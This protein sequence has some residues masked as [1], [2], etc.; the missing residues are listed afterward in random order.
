[1]LAT[2][3]D[4]PF[5][6]D[7]NWL[8]EIKWDGFRA[9]ARVDAGGFKLLGR[10]GTDFTDRFKDLPLDRLPGGT[11]V[12]GELVALR[13]D[14]KPDFTALLKSKPSGLLLAYVA[15]DLL[16]LKGQSVMAQPCI[17]RRE[18]L[19]FLIRK[20]AD[21]RVIM[22]EGVNGGGIAYFER[23]IASGLEGVMAKRLDS[24]YRPG[25]RSTDWVKL[26]A[27]QELVAVVVG[28]EPDDTGQLRNLVIAAPVD[29]ELQHVGQVGSGISV[30]L[31][32]KLLPALRAL[33]QPRPVV[34]CPGVRGR[35]VEPK[36]VCRVSFAEWL[37]TGKLRHPVLLSMVE[38]PISQPGK[39][40]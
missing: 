39:G 9:I 36:L 5:D 6:G 10:K 3:R 33:E 30:S 40:D 11:I 20:L 7:E 16:Y 4:K 26:K 18:K 37:S 32:G 25:I 28:Y 13:P 15:F 34:P 19:R 22:S 38:S 2:S 8:F 14:G 23:V 17:Q 29:G 12:D 31:A 1:M 21:K 35:W 27:R 24:P